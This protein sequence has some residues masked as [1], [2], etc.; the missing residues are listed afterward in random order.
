M[1]GQSNFS[2]AFFYLIKQDLLRMVEASR[3]TGSIHHITTSTLIALIP[4][5]GDAKSFHDFRSISLCNISFKIIT[6]IIAQRIKATL[7]SFLTKDQHAFLKGWNILDVVA[8]TQE[9]MF[10][11]ISKNSDAAILKIDLQKAYN[12]LHWG[13]VECLLAKISLRPNSI[14]WIMECIENVYYAV[15]I[16]GIP[17][18]FFQAERGLRQ[19]CP[20]SPLLFILAMNS[21]SIHI[22][23]EVVE[24]RCTPIKICRNKF[25]SHNLF[26]DDVLIF[27]MIF[28]ISWI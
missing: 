5:K 2:P 4:T 23:K 6:K 13:F 27:A 28:R 9:C 14:R 12:Y 16:N 1:A 15:I 7:A 24:N 10:S 19:G 20:L 11:M 18:H 8:N 26:V 25:I 3:M 17:S 22:N 21:V